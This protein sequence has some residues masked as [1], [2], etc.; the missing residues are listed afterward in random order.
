MPDDESTDPLLGAIELV[1]GGITSS[2][3]TAIDDAGVERFRSAYGGFLEG[4]YANGDQPPEVVEIANK[5][6]DL[7]DFQ[8]QWFLDNPNIER[9]R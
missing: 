9:L 2:L 1:L 8:L 5:L 6:T 4:A 7:L 3:V